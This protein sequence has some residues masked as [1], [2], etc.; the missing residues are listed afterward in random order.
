MARLRTPGEVLKAYRRL[1]QHHADAHCELVHENPFQLLVATV[2]SAQTTDVA[3]NKATPALFALFPTAEAMALAPDG[4]IE[5][6]IT[7]IGMF[8]QK[9]RNVRRL[10]EMLVETHGG[11]VPEPLDE[12]VILP[13]VGRKT[14]NVV[15]GVAF[16]KA[17]GVVVDTH[18]Q[19]ITQRLGW[20][21]AVEP[22]RIEQDLMR[23]IPRADWS[24]V[25]HV[26]I[27][28]GRRIC[29]AQRPLCDG[30]P[31]KADCPSA[32]NAALV[33]R[34]PKKVRGSA[35]AKAAPAKTAS[36][37]TRRIARS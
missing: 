30:C 2:L 20:T 33:G 14:A 25:S 15:L 31:V 32:G 18:V 16:D 21:R 29:G 11:R 24:H 19:R 12:L 37:K 8:R 13:G 34:K 9:A 3:V 27:F 23:L 5:A 17:E 26:L 36:K 1:E 22:I 6:R 4:A 10:S 7:S 35:K 28:H